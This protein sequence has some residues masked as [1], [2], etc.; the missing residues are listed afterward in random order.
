MSGAGLRDTRALVRRQAVA[1]AVPSLA[2]VALSGALMPVRGL[3]A[4]PARVAAGPAVVRA[5]S[6]MPVS[7]PRGLPRID[8]ADADTAL[9]V[10]S[11][12][13]FRGN[14]IRSME[15]FFRAPIETGCYSKANGP[16]DGVFHAI[17]F[18]SWTPHS[19][20]DLLFRLDAIEAEWAKERRPADM[21]GI[22]KDMLRH[23]AAERMRRLEADLLSC[24]PQSID[25]AA[26]RIGAAP[27][28]AVVPEAE[29]PC[30]VS[31]F[32][33]DATTRPLRKWTLQEERE[34][35]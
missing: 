35:G 7:V 30:P 31:V 10:R 8:M 34:D 13:G 2:G 23:E 29:V 17:D 20:E 21:P 16:A 26:P 22:V 9:F 19:D 15:V 6:L 11:W 4:P 25:H 32:E 14:N 28:I 3:R 18:P 27:S 5:E 33:V 24:Q 1:L 12:P